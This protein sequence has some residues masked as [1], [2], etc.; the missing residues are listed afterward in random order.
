MR[1]SL[2][3]TLFFTLILAVFLAFPAGSVYGDIEDTITKSFE[4]AAGG[5]LI[6]DTSLGSIE[7]RG[8]QGNTVDVEV[9]RKV[10]T[11]SEEKAEDILKE[12]EVEFDHQGKDVTIRAKDERRALRK[13]WDNIGKRLNVKYIISVPR[14]YNAQLST[15]GGSISVEDINGEI[16]SKTSGGSLRY[17]AIEGEIFGRTSGGS[18]TIG[19]VDARVDVHTSGGGIKIDRAK[20]E[21]DAH[22]SGGSITVEEVMGAVRVATSGGSINAYI[23]EQPNSDC[24]LSTSGGSIVVKMASHIRVNLDAKTS[25]GRVSTEFPVT[26]KGAIDKSKLKAEINGGGPQMLLRTSGGSIYIQEK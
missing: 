9:I 16:R 7:L 8:K 18:I 2:H 17:D 15:S 5:K 10:K 19:E 6:V 3:S 21:I 23:S 13:F 12:F 22:T 11:S 25:G 24:S 1:S 14:I 4:V 26:I 20:G